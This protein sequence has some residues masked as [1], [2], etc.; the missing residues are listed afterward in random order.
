MRVLPFYPPTTEKD[1]AKK[2]DIEVKEVKKLKKNGILDYSGKLICNLSLDEYIRGGCDYDDTLSINLQ[3]KIDE[4]I[5]DHHKDMKLRKRVS[6]QLLNLY[7]D[8]FLQI[9]YKSSPMIKPSNLYTVKQVAWTDKAQ[10][11]VMELLKQINFLF[12]SHCMS[13]MSMDSKYKT[14]YKVHVAQIKKY[15]FVTLAIPLIE[16]KIKQ[17]EGH[18]EQF[19]SEL[20]KLS[21]DEQQIIISLNKLREKLEVNKYHVAHQDKDNFMYK[22]SLKNIPEEEQKLLLL[23]DDGNFEFYDDMATK[24]RTSDIITMWSRV[25]NKL[26]GNNIYGYSDFVT[27][28]NNRKDSIENHLLSKSDVLAVIN[29]TNTMHGKSKVDDVETAIDEMNSKL[30]WNY[31]F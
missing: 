11:E 14:K 18:K 23:Q 8:G 13:I 28:F 20:K 29:K 1:A 30:K 26:T 3:K 10:E 15:G 17:L 2:L 19:Q 4:M 12:E 24:S 6:S 21:S 27:E 31:N 5:I 25:Q 22:S 16:K 7:N 9:T